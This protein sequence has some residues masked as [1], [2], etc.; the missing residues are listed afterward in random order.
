M[1]N[2]LNKHPHLLS[3][4]SVDTLFTVLLQINYHKTLMLQKEQ[5]VFFGC[6]YNS[7]NQVAGM[8]YLLLA[9]AW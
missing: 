2:S 8:N 4:K 3:E 5:K 9:K 7:K 1:I 6:I